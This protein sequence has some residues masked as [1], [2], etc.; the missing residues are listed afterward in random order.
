MSR[1]AF[2]PGTFDPPTNGH[3]EI[4]RHA[5]A[6]ADGVVVGI[7]VN[8]AKTPLF[9]VAE[10][11]AMITE[12]V[13]AASREDAGRVTVTTFGGLTVDAAREAGASVIVRGVRDGRDVDYEMQMA[14]MNAT[15]APGI[16]SVFVPASPATRHITATLVRQIAAMGRDVAPFVPEVVAKAIARKAR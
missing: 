3:L 14:A 13:K 8:A 7:G 11:Q 6:L 5:L 12:A 10:R 15:L 16:T 2:F 4:I 1:I 9:S